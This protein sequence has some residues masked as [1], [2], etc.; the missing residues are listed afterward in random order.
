M[1]NVFNL[2]CI[3]SFSIVVFL[4]IFFFFRDLNLAQSI[5]TN[6]IRDANAL[7]AFK[8]SLTSGGENLTSWN[9]S[10]ISTICT[11]W[12]GVQ[13]SYLSNTPARVQKLEL[14]RK[15]L[16]GS[17][18]TSTLSKLDAMDTLNLK[19]NLLYGPIPNDLTN[20][21]SL[22]VL[23][24]GD[25]DLSGSLVD[26]INFSL[27]PRLQLLDLYSNSFIGPIPPSITSL[28]NLSILDLGGNNFTGPIPQISSNTLQ[29]FDVS[30]NMLEGMIPKSLSRF[31]KSSF[32]G[33]LNLCGEPLS[34]CPPS[35][36]PLTLTSP[37]G[38]MPIEPNHSNH[39]SGHEVIA[40]QILVALLLT[41]TI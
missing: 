3:Y 20:C 39:I 4:F 24:L 7:L 22:C 17:I 41:W 16:L 18:P 32:N 30:D 26:N 31:T 5:S 29:Y 38:T 2:T 9:S 23:S 1:G 40:S 36:S 33:N 25:N 28:T 19:S 21:D 8:L 15:G 10:S 34:S 35:P 27:W 6:L 12:E 13:C 14:P 37:Y 11:S